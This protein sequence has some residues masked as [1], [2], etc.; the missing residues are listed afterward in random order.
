ML[1]LPRYS[2]AKAP[3]KQ[4][5]CFCVKLTE[6]RQYGHSYNQRKLEMP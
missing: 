3:A 4:G 6:D 2:N 5:R 1:R